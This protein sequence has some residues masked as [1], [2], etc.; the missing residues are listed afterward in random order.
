MARL[1]A[2]GLAAAWLPALAACTVGSDP[3]T[4]RPDK[5]VAFATGW[6]AAADCSVQQLANL[7]P[8]AQ[9]THHPE[10][11]SA[12]IVVGM[13][14]DLTANAAAAIFYTGMPSTGGSGYSSD[15]TVMIIDFHDAQPN[16]AE[17]KIFAARYTMMP[18]G[19]VSQAAGALAACR[20][21]SAPAPAQPHP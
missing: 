8:V 20:T 1:V 16:R 2:A 3:R 15:G 7:Y 4:D 6:Q 21:G 11:G 5:T 9:L 17:A 10:A 19:T 14:P 18:G 13:G 12:E